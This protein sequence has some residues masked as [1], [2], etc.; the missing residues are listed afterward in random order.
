AGEPECGGA[1]SYSCL[2]ALRLNGLPHSALTYNDRPL[3]DTSGF[4]RDRPFRW[5]LSRLK[6]L[7]WRFFSHYKQ[8]SSHGKDFRPYGR[9][10]FLCLCKEK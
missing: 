10:T 3:F 6:A 1:D 4:S 2:L 5:S 8:F 9:V 7:L